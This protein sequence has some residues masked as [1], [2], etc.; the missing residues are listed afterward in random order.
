MGFLNTRQAVL[1]LVALATLLALGGWFGRLGLDEPATDVDYE[2]IIERKQ[3][4]VLGEAVTFSELRPDGSLQYRLLA[5][6]IQQFDADRLTR[7]E[8]PDLHLTSERQPPWDVT[9]RHGYLRVRLNPQG[10]EEDVVFLREDVHMVQLHPRNGRLS[11]RSETMYIVPDREYAQTDEDVMIDTEVGRTRAAG[12]IA[13][14]ATG[15]LR[16]SSSASQRVH[17][18][19][20]PEQFKKS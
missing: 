19:V 13:D 3:P 15:K 20:L 10:E 14:M 2:Q 7:L 4:D 5:D 11:L 1:G 17:T 8:D 16:L 9:A 6:T 12:M 18:I